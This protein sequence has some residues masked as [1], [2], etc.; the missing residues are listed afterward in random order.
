MISRRNKYIPPTILRLYIQIKFTYTTYFKI[1]SFYLEWSWNCN[2]FKKNQQ[3]FTLS[4]PIRFHSRITTNM[5]YDILDIDVFIFKSY[6]NL[7]LPFYIVWWHLLLSTCN[8]FQKH[9]QF[10]RFMPLNKDILKTCEKY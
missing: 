4:I 7:F 2:A 1:K 8:C 5:S 10:S 9:R 6:N 3:F